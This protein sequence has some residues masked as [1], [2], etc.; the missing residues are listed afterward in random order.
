MRSEV[1]RK[2]FLEVARAKAITDSCKDS[3]ESVKSGVRCYMHFAEKVLNKKTGRLPPS[4]DEL[5]A[6]S[7]MFR[8]RCPPQ[9]LA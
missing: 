8:Y 9:N 1:D 2:T 6:W 3:L 7:A 5:L 4:V